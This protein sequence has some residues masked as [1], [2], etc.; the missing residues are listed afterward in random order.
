MTASLFED[1]FCNW[2]RQL[3]KEK[4]KY[5]SSGQLPGIS[6]AVLEEH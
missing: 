4:K 2:Y 1:C 3:N 6:K 5:P